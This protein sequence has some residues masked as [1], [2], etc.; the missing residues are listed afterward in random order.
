MAGLVFGCGG[1]LPEAALLAEPK[2]L[3]LAALALDLAA[4]YESPAEAA[5]DLEALLGG[6]GQLLQHAQRSGCVA[7]AREPNA[8][9]D[10]VSI[11]MSGKFLSYKTY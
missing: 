4:D 6:R 5:R 8:A 11:V 1:Q 9:G 3:Y 7:P 2:V 10:R